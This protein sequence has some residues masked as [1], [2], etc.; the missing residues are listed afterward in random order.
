[1]PTRASIFTR[2]M[3]NC[4]SLTN[5][6]PPR[7]CL[8]LAEADVRPPR[9][10]SEFDA[11][12]KPSIPHRSALRCSLFLERPTPCAWTYTDRPFELSREVTLVVEAALRGHIGERQPVIAQLFL[13]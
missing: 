7:A 8:H 4:R 3:Q 6:L 13:G 10:K 1:M 5:G 11:K 9:R 2:A 12:L